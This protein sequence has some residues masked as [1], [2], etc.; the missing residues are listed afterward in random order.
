[1]ADEVEYY[2]VDMMSALENALERVRVLEAEIDT[3][4]SS[5]L[6][7]DKELS[8]AIQHALDVRLEKNW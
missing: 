6:K 4:V 3:I 1:V 8:K 7:S 2:E 5:G